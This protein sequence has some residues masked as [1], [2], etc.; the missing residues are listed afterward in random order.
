MP[1]AS[2]LVALLFAS[3]VSAADPAALLLPG[4]YRAG[5]SGAKAGQHWFAL[6]VDEEHSA[7]VD[8]PVAVE[9]AA[10]PVFGDQ[11]GE[12]VAAPALASA[13]LVLL[14]NLPLLRAGDVVTVLAEPKDLARDLPLMMFLNSAEAYRLTLDCGP[15][16]GDR[17]RERC[18]LAFA[19][20]G[21]QQVLARFEG[22]RGESGQR[23]LGTDAAPALLWAGDVDRD[24]RLDLLLDLSDHF[25]VGATSLLLSTAAGPGEL[26]GR[27]VTLS[28]RPGT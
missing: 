16:K 22:S 20:G 11:P 12:R 5:E 23:V 18:T 7:L 28:R 2:A 3:S 27:A 1:R 17:T 19:R 9:P 6:V 4:E 14:R 25:D 10:D 24:G 8:T 15:M 21:R 26:V 13:P